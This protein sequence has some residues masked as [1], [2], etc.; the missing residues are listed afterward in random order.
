N[1][2]IEACAAGDRPDPVALS[3]SLEAPER[4]LLYDILFESAAEPTWDEAS[5]CLTALRR[6]HLETELADL[7]RRI[8]AGPAAEELRELMGRKQELR[9]ALSSETPK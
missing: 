4:R 7:Q 9:K 6:V 2:L 1:A 8:E 3:E 5:S